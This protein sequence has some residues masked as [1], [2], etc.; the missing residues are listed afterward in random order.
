MAAF[1]RLLWARRLLIDLLS[2]ARDHQGVASACHELSLLH[3]DQKPPHR[4]L[5][6]ALVGLGRFAEASALLAALPESAANSGWCTRLRAQIDKAAAEA[7][8]FE[9][10]SNIGTAIGQCD[11]L[12]KEWRFAEAE[13]LI[14]GVLQARPETLEVWQC[15]AELA[16]EAGQSDL[17]ASRWA[18]IRQLFPD[19]PAGFVG[20][21]RLAETRMQYQEAD[22]LLDEA[23][24]FLA[25][26]PFLLNAAFRS[27]IRRQRWKKAALLARQ[28]V[29]K[30]P[31]DPAAS[32]WVATS[33]LGPRVGRAA[34]IPLVLE[35]LVELHAAFP[36]FVPGYTAH[37]QA[38]R[39][40]ARFDEAEASAE[41]WGK[42]FPADPELAIGR[43]LVAQ[44]V[45]R[46]ESAIAW[47]EETRRLAP[48]L[49]RLEAAYGRAL[50]LA[51][52]E[53][54]AEAQVIEALARFPAD[55]ELLQENV[56]LASSRGDWQAA[57][58]R[59]EHAARAHPTH[60]RLAT[61]LEQARDNVALASPSQAAQV[62]APAAGFAQFES[63]GGQV[64]GCEFGFVQ[65][66]FGAEPLSLLRWA[67]IGPDGL[68]HGLRTRFAQLGTAESTDVGVRR[69]SADHREYF[70]EDKSYG[71]W[72]HSF[73]NEDA[74]PLDRMRE[75][76]LRRLRY[77]RDKLLEDLAAG[78]KIFV[79]KAAASAGDDSLRALF[80][81][82]R[83]CGGRTLL[84]ALA[85]DQAHPAG[86]L[87]MV[88]PGFFLTRLSRPT[89][90]TLPLQE[91][92]D[93]DQW[94]AACTQVADWHAANR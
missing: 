70:V 34:R 6:I 56:V 81:A 91:A 11:V 60:R 21:I 58:V 74:M 84:C 18:E 17:A 43:A 63:L 47:L 75:Q 41:L 22:R 67:N 90:P 80:E 45:G 88:T 76:S 68:A 66:H 82:L 24:G 44:D 72:A 42:R 87:E 65:R 8:R 20:G 1:P 13:T 5:A 30:S 86:P 26:V 7:A 3:P 37:L 83:G 69:V 27:A 32:L 10:I 38:L 15:A 64:G 94:H 25:K 35:R 59:A 39:E 40:A 29:A 31:K 48:N 71:Y 28:L 53:D 85:A 12:R 2:E 92:I 50:R 79:Y 46:H 36:D 73:V 9:T 23:A 57:L 51:G 4:Q 52:R 55:I 77:L 61:L 54:E 93:L 78:E 49:P 62:A 33:L 19:K 16:Q 14:A 89:D